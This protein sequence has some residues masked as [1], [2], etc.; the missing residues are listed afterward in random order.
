MRQ[1][2]LTTQRVDEMCWLFGTFDRD[3]DYPQL[4]PPS[5]TALEQRVEP[6]A[7]RAA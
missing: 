2:Y 4:S 7:A 1:L 6:V 5:R 3:G